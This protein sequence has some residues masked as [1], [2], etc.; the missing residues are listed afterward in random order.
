MKKLV[1]FKEAFGDFPADGAPILTGAAERLLKKK[2]EW[3]PETEVGKTAKGLLTGD[4]GKGEYAR[5]GLYTVWE[6]IDPTGIS[7]YD[8]CAEALLRWRQEPTKWNEFLY[9]LNLFACIPNI[10]LAIAVGTA[11][12]GIGAIA[13]SIVGAGWGAAKGG[14]K[15]II[16]NAAKNPKAVEQAAPGVIKIM[17]STP[18]GPEAADKITRE[19]GGD[20]EQLDK[21]RKTF[22]EGTGVTLTGTPKPK[23]LTGAEYMKLSPEE[24][25]KYHGAAFKASEN[26]SKLN[27][28]DDFKT[29]VNNQIYYIGE[30]I[31]RDKAAGKTVKDLTDQEKFETALKFIVKNVDDR[32]VAGFLEK[33]QKATGLTPP[34]VAETIK[35]GYPHIKFDPTSLPKAMDAIE[36]V[37]KATKETSKVTDNPAM[38]AAKKHAEITAAAKT[39]EELPKAAK[40][41]SGVWTLF[42]WGFIAFKGVKGVAKPLLKGAVTGAAFLGQSSIQAGLRLAGNSEKAGAQIYYDHIKPAV[43]NAVASG[44]LGP[45]IGGLNSSKPLGIEPYKPGTKGRRAN[46]PAYQRNISDADE[47]EQE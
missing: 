33:I 29:M 36:D 9:W 24:K 18:G 7:S 10:G 27:A 12:T 19:L 31:A 38:K 26:F 30:K 4:A 39:V 44:A 8:D 22:G 25:A 14:V 47:G 43:N 1:S 17:K 37:A 45:G 16:K 35:Q 21:V 34:Q 3:Q 32:E 2:Q 11:V 42:R 5:K 20:V 13:G 41:A 6:L 40:Q 28:S 23:E 46:N 15:L